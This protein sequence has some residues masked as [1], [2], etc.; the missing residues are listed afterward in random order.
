MKQQC[1]EHFKNILLLNLRAKMIVELC[2]VLIVLQTPNL[3]TPPP[4]PLH[5]SD[6]YDPISAV[7]STVKCGRC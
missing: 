1:P 4:K 6:C 5:Q 3:K 7:G 2:E